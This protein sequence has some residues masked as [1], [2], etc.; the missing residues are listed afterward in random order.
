MR[1]GFPGE[2][3]I[4]MPGILMNLSGTKIGMYGVGGVRQQGGDGING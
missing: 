3:D 1:K 4:K 2:R